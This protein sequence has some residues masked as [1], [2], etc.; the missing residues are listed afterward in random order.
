[1]REKKIMRKWECKYIVC[2]TYE[3]DV[4]GSVHV[5]KQRPHTSSA[6]RNREDIGALLSVMY[7]T[8]QHR[9]T[10]TQHTLTPTYTQHHTHTNTQA[11]MHTRTHF[12][13]Y[14]HIEEQLCQ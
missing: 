14:L 6:F 7:L 11:C 10:L 3:P 5:E 9:Q 12:H 13:A 1:M 2:N 8:P 4:R